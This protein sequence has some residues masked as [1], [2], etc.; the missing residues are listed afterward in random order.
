[1]LTMSSLVPAGPAPD[2]ESEPATHLVKGGDEIKVRAITQ[3]VTFEGHR[4]RCVVD[5]DVGA[6]ER[7]EGQLR[8]AQKMEAIGHLAGG[9]AHDFNNLLTVISGYGAMARERIGAGP[10]G[11]ELTEIERAAE[12]AAQLTHQLLAFSRQ[13]VVDPVV[14]DLNEVI[15]AVTPMLARLIGEHIEIG[16]LGADDVP[17]VFTDR[18]Q[19]EQAIVNLAVNARDAMPNGGTLSIETQRVLLDERYAASHVGVKPGVYACIAVSDTGVGIDR[20]T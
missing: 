17:H 15:A 1:A 13:Q 2:D 3:D 20:E 9:V 11:R 6:R 8:Q 12:R 5:E 18:G 7:L 16:V 10:G 4:A 14:L 19:I